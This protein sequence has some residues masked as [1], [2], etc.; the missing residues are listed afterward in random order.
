MLLYGRKVCEDWTEA[1]YPVMAFMDIQHTLSTGCVHCSGPARLAG[2]PREAA[3][4]LHAALEL[5]L[6]STDFASGTFSLEMTRSSSHSERDRKEKLELE[7]SSN[8]KSRNRYGSWLS[9][10]SASPHRLELGE[11]VS[12]ETS[13]VLCLKSV[14]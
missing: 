4:C 8:G 1:S 2:Q 14:G 5:H 12:G 9:R 13:Q 7:D 11:G 3:Q 6:K 10:R